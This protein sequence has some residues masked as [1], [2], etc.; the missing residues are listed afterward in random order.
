LPG[1]GS[2]GLLGQTEDAGRRDLPGNRARSVFL[3]IPIPAKPLEDAS[4]ARST[5]KEVFL[6]SST[7]ANSR[8]R[9][10]EEDCSLDNEAEVFF[11]TLASAGRR[12]RLE[13]VPAPLLPT[14]SS[15]L[16]RRLQ[17]HC[18]GTVFFSALERE[19]ARVELTKKTSFQVD[20]APE[21]LPAAWPVLEFPKRRSCPGFQEISSS[22]I[23]SLSKKTPLPC[24]GRLPP[25]SLSVSPQKPRPKQGIPQPS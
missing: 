7:L 22:S 9:A 16:E 15:T 5:W 6:V 19:L 25:T 10:E 21:R 2:G 11:P 23:L 8:S 1:Q 24:P 3:E 17:P 18:L 14:C 20:R 13:L 4:G 12:S